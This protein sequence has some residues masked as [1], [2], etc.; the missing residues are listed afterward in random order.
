VGKPKQRR[1]RTRSLADVPLYSV[2]VAW[3]SED[4]EYVATSP[5]WPELS[6]LA[7]SEP[8]AIRG[9]RRVIRESIAALEAAG[10]RIPAPHLRPMYSGQLRLR[11][12]RSLHQAMAARAD[13]EGVSL[14]TLAL[15]YLS[16][17]V[18]G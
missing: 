18:G 13:Q 10:S 15:T 12:P 14:N 7:S 2:M 4:G 3:S 9:L 5:E 11:M 6:W 8:G 16:R 1:A 17:G